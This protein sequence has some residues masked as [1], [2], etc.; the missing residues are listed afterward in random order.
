MLQIRY[1]KLCNP[2]TNRELRRNRIPAESCVPV[3]RR[4]IHVNAEESITS[5][6]ILGISVEALKPYQQLVLGVFLVDAGMMR[7][8]R[9][10]VV[11]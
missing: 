1:I 11:I 10:E 3:L 9:S 6:F 4:Q 7:S 8:W 5:S 2:P